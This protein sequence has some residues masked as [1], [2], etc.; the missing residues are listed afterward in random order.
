M[1]TPNIAAA[2]ESGAENTFAPVVVPVVATAHPSLP[3]FSALPAPGQ[4]CPYSG[5][6]RGMLYQLDKEGL[7]RTVSLR[8]KGTTRARRL[9]VLSTLMEYL[10]GLDAAQNGGKGTAGGK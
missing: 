9:I 8:R 7:I 5:L 3:E 6:K 4:V 1:S 2:S 10:R